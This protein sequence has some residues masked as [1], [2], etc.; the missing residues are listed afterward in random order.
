MTSTEQNKWTRS[1]GDS[2]DIVSSVG[3]TALGVAAQ[4]AIEATRPDA[5]AH[6]QYAQHFIRAAGEPRLIGMIDNAEIAIRAANSNVTALYL[7]PD[8]DRGPEL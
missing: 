6:D 3:F 8:I 2:W 7:E 5:L 4:R 1:D